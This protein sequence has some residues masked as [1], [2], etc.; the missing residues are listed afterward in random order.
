MVKITLFLNTDWIVCTAYISLSFFLSCFS[1]IGSSHCIMWLAPCVMP[2]HTM[3]RSPKMPKSVCRSVSQN[4]SAS[5][6]ASKPKRKAVCL[7]LHNVRVWQRELYNR[8]HAPDTLH[9]LVSALF[10]PFI[11]VFGYM[12]WI[13]TSLKINNAEAFIHCCT[14]PPRVCMHAEPAT[15]A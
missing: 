13:N 3:A 11:Y 9:D 10:H 12:P 14:I 1:R 4:A 2:F 7:L 6:P 5:S 8:V 15:S